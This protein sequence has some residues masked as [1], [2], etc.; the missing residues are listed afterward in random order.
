VASLNS[1][2]EHELAKRIGEELGRLRGELESGIA[3]TDYAKYQ[4]YVGKIA[5]YMRV[6]T[7]FCS[8]VNDT[9][10]KR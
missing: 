10:N 9:I 5:A 1:Q 4:N 6:M 8:E 7:D 3:V 2:F